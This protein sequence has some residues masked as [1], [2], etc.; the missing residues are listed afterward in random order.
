[1]TGID[2]F[3][4]ACLSPLTV[5]DS[6]REWKAKGACCLSWFKSISKEVLHIDINR[7]HM[8]QAKKPGIVSTSNKP[9]SQKQTLIN[10]APCLMCRYI[11]IYG[12]SLMYVW[13][14]PHFLF[15][16]LLP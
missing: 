5:L 7:L 9:F 6:I 16:A 10:E 14:S 3:L 13:R 11:S 8:S 4:K 1:M 12:V 2:T 15:R